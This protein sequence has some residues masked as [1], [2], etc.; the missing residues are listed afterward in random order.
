M[1]EVPHVDRAAKRSRL[2]RRLCIPALLST[3]IGLPVSAEDWTRFRGANGAGQSTA[4]G[5]PQEWSE[6]RNL[7]WKRDLPGEGSSSPVLAGDRIF[8]TCYA[9]YGGDAGADP[10]KMKRQLVCIGAEKGE[11][12]WT[13]QAVAAPREDPPQGYILE[14]GYASNSA[15]TDGDRVYAFF[16]KSGVAAY[17]LEGKEL[18]ARSVGTESANRQWGSAASLT[19]FEDL[20][21]VNAAEEGRAVLGL[22]KLTG[23]QVWK[24]EAAALEL[25]YGTPAQ[26]Q[27]ADGQTELI[28]AVP[29]EVWGLNARTGKLA[30]Y[31]ETPL[32]GNVSPSPL[33]DGQAIY[34]FGGF[35]S[36]GSL[37]VR[38]G[39][40][41][42]VTQTHVEW[43]SRSSSYVA[44]PVLVDG[45]L[46]WVDDQGI[47]WCL[48]A[49]TGETIY[50]ERVPGLRSGGRPVYASP[51][52]AE[53]HIYVVTRRDGVLVLPAEREFRVL[54]QNRFAG[55]DS[56]FNA[57]PA[58]HGQRL[59]LRSNRALYC[60]GESAK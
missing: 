27:R 25:A 29:G 44:T 41:G 17:D 54:Q 40:R 34:V 35:R 36:S 48:D 57:T 33:V 45:R 8:V 18:W 50:R 14:H 39:G 32:T 30:W 23:E 7:V 37:R 4:T 6:S 12:L 20:L 52:A 53:G 11:V 60:V 1:T 51:I 3:L 16:G 56:D 43:T 49:G 15:V 38:A 2:W 47:A 21:I 58:V 9:E 24:S 42:D 59:L 5:L 10:A 13:A 28:L 55:D 26:L 46:Y 19:L 31:A 22:N